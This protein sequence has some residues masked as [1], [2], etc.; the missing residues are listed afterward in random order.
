MIRA[1]REPNLSRANRSTFNEMEPDRSVPAPFERPMP[2]KHV[3][4]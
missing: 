1:H 4:K 3:R 2:K